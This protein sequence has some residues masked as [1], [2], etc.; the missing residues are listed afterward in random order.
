MDK[1]TNFE[2]ILQFTELL[3]QF[4]RIT[5]TVLV[6]GTD[7]NENDMEHSYMLAMQA[8]YIISL[9]NLKLNRNKVMS[10]CL[11]HD[12]VEVYA[13]DTP[14]YST[15]KEYINSKHERE[16]KALKQIISEFPEYKNLIK[17]IE[18][19]EIR[20]DDESRFVYA[21]DKIQPVIHIYLDNGRSWKKHNVKL[22]SLINNKKDKVKFSPIVEKYWNEL[23]DIL[24]QNQHRLF[25]R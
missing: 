14:L 23:R 1:K 9:E 13:G 11:V 2:K 5:R 21:L 12:F 8:D 6:N 22:G 25:S 24:E 18:S 17:T 7:R 15:D 3:N 16:K 20:L 10:Y 4:R 19:Y